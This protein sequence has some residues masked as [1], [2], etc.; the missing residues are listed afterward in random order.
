MND[1]WDDSIRQNILFKNLN[2]IYKHPYH[3]RYVSSLVFAYP[4]SDAVDDDS[5][6]K[7]NDVDFETLLRVVKAQLHR[8]PGSDS[9][10]P[11]KQENH[12]EHHLTSVF[13]LFYSSLWQSKCWFLIRHLFFLFQLGNSALISLNLWEWLQNAVAVIFSF[14]HLFSH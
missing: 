6:S 8:R 14:S 2:N 13:F 3:K 11:Y 5:R 1:D 9:W 10:R 4:L 12:V 7:A